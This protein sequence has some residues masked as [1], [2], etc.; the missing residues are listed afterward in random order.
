LRRHADWSTPAFEL[1]PIADATGPFPRR[2][3]LE[4]AG[5]HNGEL[6]EADDA[7]A[8]LAKEGD[9]LLFAGEADL[10]DYH[11]PLGNGVENLFTELAGSEIAGGF[12]LD[13]L[14]IEA[15][16]PVAKGLERGGLNVDIERHTVAAVLDLPD[17]FDDYLSNIGKKQRHEVRRKRRRYE[18]TVGELIYETHTEPCQALEEFFRL[19]R[20]S[21]GA[22]GTF[23]TEE[24]EQF[25]RQLI[26]QPGWR[27]DVLRIPGEDRAAAGLF[28][29]VDD[30]GMYLYNSAYD[31]GLSEASP[32][33]AII[34]AAIERA[35]HEKLRKFDFLKGD[36]VY[37]FRLGA[38][39][40][41]LFRVRAT[42]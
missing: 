41:P 1:R 13:S 7:L 40:R 38:E 5:A 6:F 15:A 42:A 23:M 30:Q 12:D 37:K 34:G 21:G 22:K 27:I 14:P 20:M 4:A 36:E 2:P 18:E 25:F 11:A 33:V 9:T 32:G 35:I 19:H 16:E 29:F 8:V 26:E 28:L 24:H 10:T 39:E 3:F 17:T 31:P